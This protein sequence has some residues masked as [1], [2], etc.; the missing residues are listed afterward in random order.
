MAQAVAMICGCSGQVSKYMQ[1][2]YPVVDGKATMCLCLTVCVCCMLAAWA[3]SRV[4]APVEI[5]MK[6]VRYAAHV[7]APAA[8]DVNA[9]T[10]AAT[11]AAHMAEGVDIDRQ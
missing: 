1:C 6:I 9:A 2:E 3:S 4:R 8:I 11:V 7:K 10:N 5:T